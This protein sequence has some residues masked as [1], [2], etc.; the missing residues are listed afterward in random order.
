MLYLAQVLQQLQDFK[1]SIPAYLIGGIVDRGFSRND[2]DI[3][4]SSY[5]YHQ[6]QLDQ[7]HFIAPE[8]LGRQPGSPLLPLGAPCLWDYQDRRSYPLDEFSA[9]SAHR[10]LQEM[11]LLLQGARVLD[12]GCGQ[13]QSLYHFSQ[14]GARATGIATSAEDIRICRLHGLEAYLM[15]QNFLEFEDD[16]FD[17][18]W[19]HHTLEHSIAPILAVR[20]TSR[21]LMPG[22]VFH[23][24]VGTGIAPGHHYRFDQVT[25]ENMLQDSGFTIDKSQKARCGFG[26]ELHLRAR[27][28][29]Q[30]L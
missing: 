2:V 5:A 22:G 1:S 10:W 28:T 3:L 19:S 29:E 27:K 21:I 17:I 8:E 7:A 25:L 23:L 14:A 26:T 30:L 24:T 9:R 20:E 12:I 4:L 18:V 13:G 15:D 11:S 16:S 6:P